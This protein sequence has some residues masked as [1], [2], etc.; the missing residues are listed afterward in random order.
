[1]KRDKLQEAKEHYR[2]AAEEMREQYDRIREDFDFSNPSAPKQWDAYATKARAGRPMHT[3]DRTHQY[4]QHVVNTIRAQKTSAQVFAVDG[5]ADVAVAKFI[6]GMFRHIEYTSRAD[7]A[8]ATGADH[9]VRGGLGWVR[10]TPKVVDAQDNEQEILI[11]RVIDPTSC[12]LEAGWTEPDGSDAKKAWI[13]SIVPA[14]TFKLAYPKAATTSFESETGWFSSDS[15]RVCE[16]FHTETVMTNKMTVSMPDGQEM[17]ISE[18]EYWAMAKQIGFQPQ[19]RRQFETSTNKVKWCK[20]TG[21]EIL[22]ETDYPS[23]YIGLVPILG[24]ELWVENKRHLCGLVRRLMDGQRLHNYEMSALTEALMIQ[25]KA[26]FLVGRRAIEGFDDEWSKLN[27]GNPA[28]LTFNDYDADSGQAINAPVRLSPPSFPASFANMSN[29]AVSEMEASVG[30]FKPSL[31]AQ[32]NA[33]SGRAKSLDKEAGITA[34]YHFSD[35]L[36]ISEE[37]VYRIILDMMPTVYSGRRMAKIMGED[38]AQST[39]SLDDSLPNASHKEGG[40]VVAINL[41]AG[42]YD[43]RVKVGP[44]YTTIREEMGVKLQ[45]LGKG[46][47]V[48]AS[49]LLP[50]IMK[51][52]DMPEADQI[53]RVAIAMLPPEV[54]KAYHADDMDDMPESARAQLQSKDQELEQMNQALQKAGT[55]IE[56]LH[57]KA[58]DKNTE[59]QTSAKAAMAEIK[60]AQQALKAQQDALT[61]QKRDLDNAVRI[62]ELEL[63]LASAKAEKAIEDK[64]DQAN[65]PEP[66]KDE[67]PDAT[68]ILAEAIAKG[69]DSIAQ[70]MQASAESS[71]HL[72]AMTVDAL[73]GM[74]TAVSAPRQASIQRD[75]AGRPVGATSTVQ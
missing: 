41:G 45:E 39:I 40:K 59:V 14:K 3:L 70:A 37:R 69:H 57:G 16:Y 63:Q 64:F 47:P 17:T 60:A 58:N 34:T 31:G 33:V 72:Q 23:Q 19:V 21:A 73:R 49:A 53:A 28:F 68:A 30:I 20:M 71:K 10:V 15:V 75:G 61:A 4:V 65:T 29:M 13:E 27:S 43:V 18:S 66:E 38:D 32:S 35:N 8:W 44:S 1:M 56:E 22:E 50:V 52:S 6:V 36:R 42:R 67:G 2:D 26:P 5:G 48:L 12:L 7:I 24:S 74:A 11:Q 51:M 62:A 46:N 25:P 55:I 9:Q 54:Q